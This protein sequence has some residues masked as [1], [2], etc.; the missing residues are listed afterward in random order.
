[1]ALKHTVSVWEE[2]HMKAGKKY[3]GKDGG[4]YSY[5]RENRE[6]TSCN[7]TFFPTT[8]MYFYT[9]IEKKNQKTHLGIKNLRAKFL[10]QMH[11]IFT[12]N[13][14]EKPAVHM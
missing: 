6:E 12:Q 9:T 3:C 1:M 13:M 8:V 11:I 2:I 7:S 5:T 10:M 14:A 4:W